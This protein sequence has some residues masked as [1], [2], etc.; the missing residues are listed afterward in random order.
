MNN[1]NI[2]VITE[3]AAERGIIQL[4]LDNNLL[5]FSEEDLFSNEIIPGSRSFSNFQDR[6]LEGIK[7]DPPLKI[8]RVQD[9]LPKKNSKEFIPKRQYKHMI[10]EV[11]FVVTRAEIEKI[12]IIY[13]DLEAEFNKPKYQDVLPSTFLKQFNKKKFENCKNYE[14]VYC[15]FDDLPKLINSIKIYHN[16]NVH[17]RIKLDEPNSLSIYD[18]LNDVAKELSR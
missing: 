14:F 13:N 7:V 16:S 18:L 6:Y 3:G 8:Y 2:V 1:Q 11:L 9:T 5:I 10:E 12:M 4:L 15:H 17:R